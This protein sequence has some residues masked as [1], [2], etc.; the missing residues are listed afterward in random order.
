MSTKGPLEFC[1]LPCVL[2]FEQCGLGMIS[3]LVAVHK[4]TLA[5]DRFKLSFITLIDA[6]PVCEWCLMT[7]EGPRKRR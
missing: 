1:F 2:K 6:E 7:E 3:A 4:T 5:A